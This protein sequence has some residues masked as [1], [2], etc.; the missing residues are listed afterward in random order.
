MTF[1][2][3]KK[4]FLLL[5]LAVFLLLR[6][7]VPAHTAS[8][9]QS[10]G[11]LAMSAFDE[12]P[13][14]KTGTTVHQVSSMDKSGG[15]ADGS[16]SYFY[17]NPATGGYVVLEE[18]KPGTI[19]RIWGT[20]SSVPAGNIRIY[21]DNESTPRVDVP[22]SDFFSGLTSPFLV[23]LAG[24]NQLSSGGYYNYYP[25]SFKSAVRVEFSSNV[26][27]YYQITYHLYSTSDT[28]T[29]Y[30]GT[31]DLL[32]VYNAWK[33]PKNDP[34]DKT[35]NQTLAIPS[36]NLPAGSTA[37]LL[38]LNGNAGSI[39]S[40]VLNMPQLVATQ[41]TSNSAEVTDD[42]IAHRGDSTFTVSLNPANAGAAIIRRLDYAIADQTA[43][44]YV[45]N[46]LVGRWST[47]GSD[48]VNN[49]RDSRFDIPVEFTSGKSQINVKVQFISSSNDWNEFYYWVKSITLQ[50]G[51]VESDALDIG[52]ADQETA[53]NY[54]ITN[55]TWEGTRTFTYSGAV[56]TGYDAATFDILTK[57]RIKMY[58][59]DEASPSVD[60][61]LGFFFGLGSSG[62]GDVNGLLM[63]TDV[64][65]KKLYNYFPMPFKQKARIYLVNGSTST[66]N[67]A[68]VQL[69]YNTENAYQGLGEEAGYFT[70]IYRQENPTVYGKDYLFLEVPSGKGHVVATIQN[71]DMNNE[72]I[73]E[74]DERIFL[75]ETEFDPQIH[76]TGTEDYYNGGWYFNHGIFTLPVHGAP[77]KHGMDGKG[78]IVMYRVSV[79]DTFPFEKG[80]RFKMEHGGVNDLNYKYES[81]VFAYMVREKESLI[82][83]DNL[84]IGNSPSEISHNYS[85][86]NP[87]WQ[88]D[89]SST[90]IGRDDAP[91]SFS[92]TGRSHQG[93]SSFTA[94]ISPLN[95]GVRLG[96]IL[97]YSIANQKANVYI[98]GELGGVWFTG[99]N[100]TTHKALY[101]FFE[102][103]PGLTSGK[104]SINIKVEYL[105]A[106]KWSEIDYY[107]YSH[108]SSSAPVPTNTST[109]TPIPTNTPTPTPTPT[110]TP[111]L[112]PVPTNTPTP[113]PTATKTPT[114]T[115]TKTPTPT[116]S[117][118]LT[119][120]ILN[121][122]F[123]STY[124]T[125]FIS[126]VNAACNSPTTGTPTIPFGGTQTTVNLLTKKV[127]G[128]T[129]SL[130]LLANKW[131][132]TGSLSNP[133]R[134][135][136]VR[137][138]DGT[139]VQ[140]VVVNGSSTGVY[141]KF[142]LPVNRKYLITAS[143]YVERGSMSI[144]LTGN[145]SS[146]NIIY[147][148]VVSAK[149]SWQNISL[150]V[151]DSTLYDDSTLRIISRSANSIFYVDN[152]TIREI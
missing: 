148:N 66:V 109:P 80:M 83:T 118:P 70:A 38:D 20:W 15:N 147:S 45:D 44:V 34:K 62:F 72:G 71:I 103:S 131:G 43:D 86:T 106:D 7:K 115:P 77:L 139:H 51:E 110:T 5:L 87:F 127:T 23:P 134:Y 33:N 91:V 120:I 68:S 56:Q 54:A 35:G 140:Q 85:V 108:I 138:T 50:S 95:N 130:G 14:F 18:N 61:P 64:P 107:V 111:T 126:S 73:L 114:P 60:V 88:G 69:Q 3:K 47:P 98:D 52:K 17:Q 4:L 36:F 122:N 125:K 82:Q 24:N 149:T 104:S 146:Q 100:N 119:T 143:V 101:D 49:W 151:T 79:A 8:N 93:A 96:R 57:A 89:F 1:K 116:L 112:T 121:G 102:I 31:E 74:G 55:K 11:A 129:C 141:Q 40:F 28:V 39:R 145:N 75:D 150:T 29:T 133:I 22:L 30:T 65:N 136:N 26:P 152:V 128:T 2:M 105:S 92:G 135:D 6:H 41:Y 94:A 32:K 99:G 19:Y 76:G 113:T 46:Q 58:W 142:K 25:F 67:G 10:R 78:H 97:D 124:L 16:A 81:S 137:K 53:H 84:D 42:G 13:Y 37:T 21:F 63:G 132:L 12:L 27:Q 117:P 144:K 9:H 90:F 48:T 59:D 123:E